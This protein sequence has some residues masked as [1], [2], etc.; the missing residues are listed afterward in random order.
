MPGEPKISFIMFKRRGKHMLA[1]CRGAAK[2]CRVVLTERK[3][4][5]PC[6]DCV[7]CDDENETIGQ[8]YERLTKGNG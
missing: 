7:I 4:L 5:G 6:P 1:A 2:G 3:K 8:V